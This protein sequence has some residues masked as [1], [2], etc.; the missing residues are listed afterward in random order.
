[1]YSNCYVAAFYIKLTFH[2]FSG[3]VQFCKGRCMNDFFV[4]VIVVTA[5]YRLAVVAIS[6]LPTNHDLLSLVHIFV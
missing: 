4:I 1:M 3:A 6:T 5:V 2:V